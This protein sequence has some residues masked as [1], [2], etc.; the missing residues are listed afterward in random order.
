MT[1]LSYEGPLISVNKKFSSLEKNIRIRQIKCFFLFTGRIFLSITNS[2]D[3][4]ERKS[5]GKIISC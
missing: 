3:G 2:E 4:K 1:F 5:H